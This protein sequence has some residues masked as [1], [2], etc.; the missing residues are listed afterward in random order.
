MS[1][2]HNQIDVM[3]ED[4]IM[5]ALDWRNLTDLKR[6]WDAGE[7]GDEEYAINPDTLTRMRGKLPP[8]IRLPLIHGSIVIMTGKALTRYYEVCISC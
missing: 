2:Y 3:N 8:E 6:R 5:G 7:I 4:P 1:Y